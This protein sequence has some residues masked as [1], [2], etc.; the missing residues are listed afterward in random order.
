M[1]S[2]IKSQPIWFNFDLPFTKN[3][4]HADSAVCLLDSLRPI[5]NLSVM[6]GR[7]VLCWTST[8]LV[9]MCLAQGHNAVTLVKLEPAVPPSRVKLSTT[10]HCVP[11]ILLL[12]R[13]RQALPNAH[14]GVEVYKV[15][16]PAPGP[17]VIT[18][19]LSMEFILFINVNK[20]WHFNSIFKIREFLHV[21]KKTFTFKLTF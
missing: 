4:Y 5:I 8:K 15:S 18:S 9:L 6:W 11:P 2:V 1:L 17:E 10:S 12:Q 7:V 14:E 19:Q 16:K 3:N 13:E 21:N 20:C